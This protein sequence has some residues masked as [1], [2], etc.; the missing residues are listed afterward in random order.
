MSAD[1]VR[2][3]IKEYID[4]GV[5][6]LGI[7]AGSYLASNPHDN[8]EYSGI[9]EYNGDRDG[10]NNQGRVDLR[11]NEE[12]SILNGGNNVLFDQ[13]PI[14]Y[15]AIPSDFQVLARFINVPEKTF[16]GVNG[17]KFIDTPAI[18]YKKNID[19]GNILLF[20]VHYEN[21]NVTK[22]AYKQFFNIFDK[23]ILNLN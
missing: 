2:I 7:C 1:L 5:H 15:L 10:S 16:I 12:Y 13:G 22:T 23:C 19:K 4:M 17:K 8:F 9:F 20:T 11:I 3:K 21:G 18:L 6:Y 14:F